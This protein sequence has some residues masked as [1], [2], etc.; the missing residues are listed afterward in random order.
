VLGASC[1]GSGLARADS[2]PLPSPSWRAD[3]MPLTEPRLEGVA[4]WKEAQAR[5]LRSREDRTGELLAELRRPVAKVLVGQLG[6]S[7]GGAGRQ[8]VAWREA[9]RGQREACVLPGWV[10]ASVA[11]ADLARILARRLKSSAAA[12]WL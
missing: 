2:S 6:E 10:K 3:A 4:K 1:D 11:C 7:Q 8:E 9:V 12:P 5:E